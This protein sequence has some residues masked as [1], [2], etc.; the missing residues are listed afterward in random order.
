[1]PQSHS[2]SQTIREFNID[3]V[4]SDAVYQMGHLP[5]IGDIT[6]KSCIQND[7]A[8]LAPVSGANVDVWSAYNQTVEYAVH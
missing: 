7:L 8:W 4:A 5:N 1:M 3:T 6:E 2:R